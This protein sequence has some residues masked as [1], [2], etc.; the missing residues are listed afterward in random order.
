MS[1]LVPRRTIGCKVEG[2]PYTKETLAATDYNV[3]AYN[4]NYSP[5]IAMYARKI[6]RGGFGA[7]SSIAGK[8]SITISFSVDIQEGA[9]PSTAPTYFKCLQ[10]CG[11]KQTAYSTTGIG[12]S[13]DSDYS[14]VPMTFEIV[15][16]DEGTTPNQVVVTATGCMGNARII[17][18]SI[19]EPCKI[20]FEFKGMLDSIAQRL[21]ASIMTPTGFMANEPD[22]VM[23]VTITA[24]G[25]V[26]TLNKVTIDLSNDVQLFTDPTKTGGFSGAHIVNR[27]SPKIDIDPDLVSPSTQAFYTR[28]T[29]ETIGALLM[30]LGSNSRVTSSHLQVNKAYAPGERE[31]HVVQNLSFICTRDDFE[32]LQGAKA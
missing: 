28:W 7:E 13:L 12:L 29:S 18:N 8:R 11:M 16:K 9:T 2:T 31:G 5:E 1:F 30:T 6:A 25:D 14:N 24:F 21:F 23:S 26:Q 27:E 4:I 20:E 19:G 22:A 10:G 3:S 15:E 17:V 32:F